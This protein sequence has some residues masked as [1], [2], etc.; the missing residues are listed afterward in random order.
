M[1][2]A[3]ASDAATQPPRGKV[4]SLL[5]K[6]FERNP[7]GLNW[8]RGVMFLDVALMPYLV[9][10]G[11]QQ[12][13]LSAV[14]AVLFTG[15]A[16]RGGSY[17][18]RASQIAVFGLAGA[19]VTALG[20]GIATSGW[21]WLVFTVFVV[22]LVAG[23]TVKL[24]LHRFVAAMLLN[25]WFV[26]ALVLGSNHHNAHVTSH[27]WAQARLGRGDGA[28]DRPHVHCV[29]DSRTQGPAT[30]GRGVPGDTSPRK[31]TPP[32]IAFAVGRALGKGGA[33]A[34]AFGAHLSHAE[35]T[36]IAA[37][38]AMKPSLDQATVV[39]VQ[40][41]AGALIGAAAAVLLL[42]IA[43]AET[44]IRLVSITNILELVAIVFFLHAASIRFWSYAIYTAAIAAGVL[45][46]MDLP[47]PSNYSAEADRVLWTLVGVAIALLVMLLGNLLAKRIAKARPQAVPHPA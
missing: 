31:L 19:A 4:M 2:T 16:D 6:V 11:E 28:V 26:I 46:A 3:N 30:A 8:A 7:K 10:I 24:G 29:V 12:Y 33:T 23:L 37:I 42:L 35:W 5:S 38:V 17:G 39:A 44:G 1:T 14:F 41:L 9:A 13:L 34:I 22:T 27:V 18:E 21:G 32:L 43:A 25:I 36:P 45:I 15:V 47:H 20:F 40:R